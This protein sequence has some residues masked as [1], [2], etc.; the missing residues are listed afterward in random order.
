MPPPPPSHTKPAAAAVEGQVQVRLTRRP[1]RAGL[2]AAVR[3]E[4]PILASRLF[5]G[6]P[7]A[8]VLQLVPMLFSLCGRAQ[9][10][11]AVRAVESAAQT[12]AAPAIEQRRDLLVALEAIR[13]HLWRLS[14]DWPAALGLQPNPAHTAPLLQ[15]LNRLMTALSPN[16]EL[17]GHPGLRGPT[18]KADALRERWRPLGAAIEQQ[19]LAARAADWLQQA[20][21]HPPAAP[22]GLAEWPCWTQL[23]ALGWL[24]VGD[25]SL[26]PLP[27]LPPAALAAQLDADDADTWIG[28]PDWH[29]RL[30]ETG[31]YAVHREHARL[32][33]TRDRWGD[34][35]GSRLL[36]R[37]V[38]LA[39]QLGQV[40]RQLATAVGDRLVNVATAA[41]LAQVE[42]ARGRLTHRVQLTG[43]R[44]R[45]YRI[46]AP[47]EWN[48][49]PEGIAA[50]ALA[51]LDHPD[52][53]LLEQQ[54]RLVLAAI[55]PCVSVDL[56]IDPD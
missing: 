31:T 49:H 14:I 13:E 12:P 23:D 15:G 24:A 2:D 51:T 34:G 10:V 46:L 30:F 33:A 29:G 26:A 47:T 25:L 32:R 20:S 50:R 39:E 36:A 22:P 54:A 7:V 18:A 41:G 27:P 44:I 5:E 17:T 35:L 53:R 38:A 28:R 19:L 1:G 3:V 48:F 37:R 56:Q 11:A 45:R 9:G 52:D 8:E 40:E 55:D 21:P 42:T 6:R 43:D 4:R 16:H